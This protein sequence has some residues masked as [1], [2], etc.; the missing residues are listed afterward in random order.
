[1]LAPI[2]SDTHHYSHRYSN[3][4]ERLE[5]SIQEHDQNSATSRAVLDGAQR[6]RRRALLR[7]TQRTRKDRNKEPP[8]GCGRT[9]EYNK[10][11]LDTTTSAIKRAQFSMRHTLSPMQDP[12]LRTMPHTIGMAVTS[13]GHALQD[14]RACLDEDGAVR[15][16]TRDGLPR[17][18]VLTL[19]TQPGGMHAQRAASGSPVV[20]AGTTSHAR[21]GR[22]TEPSPRAVSLLRRVKDIE[23]R[24]ASV[25]RF[26]SKLAHLERELML[27]RT[28][29]SRLSSLPELMDVRKHAEGSSLRACLRLLIK[30]KIE[31]RPE[32]MTARHRRRAVALTVE[33]I[34]TRQAVD[35][36][37][38]M[39]SLDAVELRGVGGRVSGRFVRFSGHQDALQA[40]GF[41]TAEAAAAMHRTFTRLNG[42]M[43]T[44]LLLGR[45][46]DDTGSVRFVLGR[47]T[48]GRT[49]D[50]AQRSVGALD[51]SQAA[52]FEPLHRS[53]VDID[54]I[55]GL[56][57]ELPLFLRWSTLGDAVRPPG[58]SDADVVGRLTMSLPVCVIDDEALD[59]RS[60]L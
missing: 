57:I 29:V 3:Q 22:S 28:A 45:H 55:S 20:P 19:G 39:A 14:R 15:D 18:L 60:L 50:V 33:H 54:A 49:V 25:N 58:A 52:T 26:E 7:A 34:T 6:S 59:L 27:A 36:M 30:R 32:I 40:F 53:T 31:A 42:T 37:L 44:R 43:S 5:C 10:A 51:G 23:E 9:P 24:I 1:M 38:G 17:E 48:D 13:R 12:H 8:T 4:D 35:Q 16:W 41:S 47:S 11:V 21:A 2:P 46:V 56:P